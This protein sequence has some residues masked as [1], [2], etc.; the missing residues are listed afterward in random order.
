MPPLLSPTADDGCLRAT[1]PQFLTAACVP[2]LLG[3]SADDGS[4]VP[5]L[6]G[7]RQLACH[8][9]SATADDGSCMPP[10]T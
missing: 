8:R 2:P 10:L 3:H 7:L 1:A 5:P 4:C 9:S 6:T